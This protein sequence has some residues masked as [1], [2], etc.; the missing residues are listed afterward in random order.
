MVAELF[1][2]PDLFEPYRSIG[3]EAAAALLLEPCQQQIF[4]GTKDR[5]LIDNWG[6]NLGIDKW[7]RWV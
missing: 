6:R 7:Y 1:E 2:M 4:D 5:E 3:L